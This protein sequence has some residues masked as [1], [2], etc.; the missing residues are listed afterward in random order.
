M[1]IKI[2]NNIPTEYTLDQLYKDNKNVSFP[3]TLPNDRLAE[4]GV[5]PVT[6]IEAPYYD[7]ITHKLKQS[8]FY[9]VEGRWQV[10]YT[11]E[12]LP[13]EQAASFIRTRRDNLLAE[14]D[15]IVAK[16]YERSE[17]VPEAWA[18][19]RQQLRDITTQSGFP[20]NVTW[21][22]PPTKE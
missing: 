1:Y 6:V 14:S 10:H 18:N 22:T 5:Y 2:V 20:Y 3:D 8:D 16:S 13:I 15:W 11:V 17:P 21:P 4:Y 19:Y 7:S 9:Q 12:P